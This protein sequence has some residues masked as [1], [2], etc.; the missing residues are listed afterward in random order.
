MLN[1]EEYRQ[2]L[3]DVFE[4]TTLDTYIPTPTEVYEASMKDI[5]DKAI[6]AIPEAT[7]KVDTKVNEK[8]KPLADNIA[9][10]V[11]K[12]PEDRAKEE[13]QQFP[14]NTHYMKYSADVKKATNILNG[15]L[16]LPWIAGWWAI[17]MTATVTAGAAIADNK[18][19]MIQFLQGKATMK[20]AIE[21][22]AKVVETISKSISALEPVVPLLKAFAETDPSLGKI[23][24]KGAELAVNKLK[25]LKAVAEKS[26]EAGLKSLKS[27]LK[28]AADYAYNA[29][30]KLSNIGKEKKDKTVKE[31]TDE[32]IT[33]SY[34]EKEEM[35][36][37][38][39][40]KFAAF[41]N[42]EDNNPYLVLDEILSK[43]NYMSE[44]DLDIIDKAFDFVLAL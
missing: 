29:K 34:L 23:L 40:L 14:D 1:M 36:V 11:V 42:A 5:K 32:L 21:G 44:A 9:R 27:V 4:G 22:G 24:L 31:S 7:R 15:F 26:I 2:D 19:I 33:E 28:Y 12:S 18:E 30:E 41:E 6:H 25:S 16:N 38:T 43:C 35:D 37:L 39:Q 3:F 8:T 17:P 13:G 20:E 10:K